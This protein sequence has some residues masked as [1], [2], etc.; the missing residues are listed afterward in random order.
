MVDVEKKPT[1]LIS[2]KHVVSILIAMR[3]AKQ[4]VK[5]SD[6]YSIALHKTLDP[7]TDRM[8]REGLLTKYTDREIYL[9]T[10]LELTPKGRL[11]AEKLKEAVDIFQDQ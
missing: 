2:E 8:V 7:L 10:F 11:V 9:I 3:D 4:R 1:M 6:L 5:L